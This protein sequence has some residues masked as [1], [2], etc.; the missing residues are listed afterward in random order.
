MSFNSVY[1]QHYF[2][3]AYFAGLYLLASK[4]SAFSVN[5]ILF[6]FEWA[7]YVINK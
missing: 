3:K 5:F 1:F 6:F 7:F 2:T 4:E